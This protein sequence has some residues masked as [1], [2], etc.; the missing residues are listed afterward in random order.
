MPQRPVRTVGTK[1]VPD[2]VNG[3][4]LTFPSPPSRRISYPSVVTVPLQLLQLILVC[5]TH[6]I[7]R[8]VL[9]NQCHSDGQIQKTEMGGAYGKNG[10]RRDVYRGLVGKPEWKRPLLRPSCRWE[11]N[12]KMTL[13]EIKWRH[14]LHWSGWRYG[15]V[16]VG[17]YV[18]TVMTI[19]F[20]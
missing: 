3:Q 2:D 16:G 12:I 8:S 7:S 10:E 11:D 15:Q 5:H 4:L 9:L 20:P 13:Q 1:A 6:N 19:R 14:G 17:A 18:N